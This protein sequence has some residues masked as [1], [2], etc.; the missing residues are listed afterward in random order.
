MVYGSIAMAAFWV[1]IITEEGGCFD[2]TLHYYSQA[3]NA[4]WFYLNFVVYTGTTQ[5]F[6]PHYIV[7][8]FGMQYTNIYNTYITGYLCNSEI[9]AFWPK[10]DF[11]YVWLYMGCGYPTVDINYANYICVIQFYS[12]N[13]INI[14][15]ICINNQLFDTCIYLVL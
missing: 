7:H 1:F 6:F 12:R 2:G 15:V 8:L 3:K 10:A 11:I 14:M 13:R 9:C 4:L 5:T